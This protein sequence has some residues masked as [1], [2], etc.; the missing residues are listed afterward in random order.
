M[1]FSR[2]AQQDTASGTD[3][4][5]YEVQHYDKI[6]SFEE[7]KGAV[8]QDT[9]GTASVAMEAY[10]S[11]AKAVLMDDALNIPRYGRHHAPSRARAKTRAPRWW[12]SR[13]RRC[14]W[15]TG[16]QATRAPT[17]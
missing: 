15:T 13:C 8:M 3:Y 17:K 6:S 16:M 4:N 7:L 11:P 12:T 5:R 9:A 10:V 14:G 2:N 1:A